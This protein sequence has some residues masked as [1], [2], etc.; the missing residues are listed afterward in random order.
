MDLEP[1]S[2]IDE[3]AR[4]H[5]AD[6]A[7][8]AAQAGTLV[9]QSPNS[10]SVS[11]QHDPSNPVPNLVGNQWSILAEWPDEPSIE[12]RDDVL[13][14]TTPPL[15]Q[16][17]QLGGQ[18][19]AR[20]R[21]TWE[22]PGTQLIIKLMD[23]DELGASRGILLGAR[24]IDDPAGAATLSIELG[25]IGY[26]VQ[27]GHRLRVQIASSCFPLYAPHSGTDEQRPLDSD[28]NRQ[29]PTDSPCRAGLRLD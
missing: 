22:G 27:A 29:A 17:L 11:W 2:P 1:L 3:R 7:N 13:I 12:S 6:S 25:H 9:E 5:F 26:L 24:E 23:V 20:L 10:G 15:P 4:F 28:N 21:L 14:F 8:A 19:H 18:V 16:Q